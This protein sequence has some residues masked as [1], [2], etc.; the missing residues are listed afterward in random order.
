MLGEAVRFVQGGRLGN[1][2]LSLKS[3]LLVL[4]LTLFP[5]F[6]KKGSAVPGSLHYDC[7][8]TKKLWDLDSKLLTLKKY[9]DYRALHF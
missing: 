9:Q 3:G 8:S 7:V 5:F 1:A 2:E 4:V 6:G